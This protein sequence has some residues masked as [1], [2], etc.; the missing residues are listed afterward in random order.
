MGPSPWLWNLPE[1]SFEALP[2]GCRCS[3]LS[4]ARSSRYCRT[5]WRGMTWCV[6]SWSWG[7]IVLL[8]AAPKLGLM[9]LNLQL[10]Y[11]TR[12][13]HWS[14]SF[15]KIVYFGKQKKA[16]LFCSL[17]VNAMLLKC[18]GKYCTCLQ[19]VHQ[20]HHAGVDLRIVL[21][22]EQHSWIEWAV[23]SKHPT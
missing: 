21:L 15:K 16:I 14:C 2:W 18:E 5:G 17:Q 8:P 20:V 23:A 12:F 1:P 3:G 13:G 19:M 4:P 7:D 9:N 11:G 6:L 22:C 10:L